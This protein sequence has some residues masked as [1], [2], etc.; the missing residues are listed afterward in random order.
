MLPLRLPWLW[1]GAG[2]LVVAAVCAGSLLPASNMPWLVGLLR[3]EFMEELLHA[4]AYFVLMIWFAGLC[5]RGLYGVVAV[6]L[7]ALG[8]ALDFLQLGV[9]SRS[10]DPLDIAANALGIGVGLCA[11]LWLIGGWCQRI[12]QRLFA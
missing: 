1:L 9:P 5:R 6:L 10:F 12:E 7:V 4:G 11:A 3:I 2:C 8:A